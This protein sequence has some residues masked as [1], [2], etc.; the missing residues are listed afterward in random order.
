MHLWRNTILLKRVRAIVAGSILVALFAGDLQTVFAQS[1]A[2]PRTINYQAK[3][4]T[5]AGVAVADGTYNVWFR[6]YVA[7]V[8][9]TTTNIWQEQYTGA[10]KIA[11]T[12]GLLSTMLGSVNSLAG[13][14]FNQPL[15]LGVEIGGSTT[16]AWDGEMTPR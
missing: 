16:P 12:S 1:F 15:Y 11:V 6:L 5:P 2:S 8:S 14:N 7:P 10:N 3:L 9:A 4:T 13:V